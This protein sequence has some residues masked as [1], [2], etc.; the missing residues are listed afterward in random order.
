MH[1]GPLSINSALSQNIDN[2][3][4]SNQ[5]ETI[6]NQ[7]KDALLKDIFV[8]KSLKKFQAYLL[9]N[10]RKKIYLYHLE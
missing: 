4:F 6:L 10:I 7:K 2:N 3:L 1:L 5:L 9:I 8:E